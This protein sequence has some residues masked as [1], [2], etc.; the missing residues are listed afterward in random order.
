MPRPLVATFALLVAYLL[1][2]AAA[3][4][5]GS[6]Q[7]RPRPGEGRELEVPPP[8]IREY[9]PRS[10][11]I[12]PRHP[13]PRAKFPVIDIHGHPPPLTG[14]DVVQRVVETMDPLNLRVMVNANS[15]SGDELKEALAAIR[16][17]R[18]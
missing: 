17:S 10:T 7:L 13:V 11:L 16:A 18:T 12:V 5:P 3:Q 2:H 8:N 9:Q 14:A 1:A 4:S 15:T 6:G